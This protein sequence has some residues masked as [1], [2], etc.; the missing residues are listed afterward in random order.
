MISNIIFV[1]ASFSIHCPHSITIAAAA[2]T[3]R[4]TIERQYHMEA[5]IETRVMDVASFIIETK[6]TVRRAAKEF[7]VSKS[8]VH[9]DMTSRLRQ[10][11]KALAHEVAE[12]LEINKEERH[13]R[14]G[15]ATYLKYKALSA[16]K[17]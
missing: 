2:Y 11:D 16:A 12:I 13:I 1:F 3:Y 17:S 7:G 5:Y 14:G 10:L 6:A 8:T 15:Y 9:K 4:R